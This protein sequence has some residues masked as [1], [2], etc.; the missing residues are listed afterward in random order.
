MKLF[1]AFVSYLQMIGE[2]FVSLWHLKRWWLTPLVLVLVVFGFL[3]FLASSAAIA[4]FIY[5]LF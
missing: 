1:Q 2:L 4:P 5:T 3:L